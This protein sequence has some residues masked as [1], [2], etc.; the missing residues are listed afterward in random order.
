MNLFFLARGFF[1]VLASLRDFFSRKDA[2]AQRC[3]L[4]LYYFFCY[5]FVFGLYFYK[6][7]AGGQMGNV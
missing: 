3:F 1:C 7:N 4:I 5:C 6:I 2:R